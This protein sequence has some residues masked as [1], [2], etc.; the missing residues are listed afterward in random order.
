MT[1]DDLQQPSRRADVPA[2]AEGFTLIELVV[3]MA[4][5][6]IMLFV[7]TP[8]FSA[9]LFEDNTDAAIR[10]LLVQTGQL[11]VNAVHR[12]RDFTMHLDLREQRIWV[13][14]ETMAS[15]EEL[16]KAAASAYPLPESL[17][18][19]DV[20]FFGK[21]A[22]SQE[23]AEIH[24]FKKGYSDRAVIHLIGRDEK[25]ISLLIEPFLAT[26]ELREEYVSYPQ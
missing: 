17:R 19:T 2:G 11:K 21:G 24:F 8:R 25:P 26:V 13:A 23:T 20:E 22:V 1:S 4:V 7:A 5:I 14:D 10:F 16:E 12:Q 18:L 15:E 9:F 6:A 3:V